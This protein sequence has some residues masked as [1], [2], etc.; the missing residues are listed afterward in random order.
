[1]KLHELKS[2]KQIKPKKRIGRGGKRG[3]FSG[4][5][6]KGQ[7]SRAGRRI[8]KSGRDLILRLPKKRG[9]RNKPKSDKPAILNLS[10]IE[11]KLKDVLKDKKIIDRAVLMEFNL[12]PSG[13]RGEIKILGKGNSIAGVIF[14][15]LKI[16]KS[17]KIKIEK[18]NGQIL[19]ADPKKAVKA[20]AK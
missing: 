18:A 2:K 8:R 3:T 13:H 14:K 1:M 15:G 16:S 4:R 20:K 12:I 5:G 11:S 7:K 17:A 6:T 9:F 10:E 19:V